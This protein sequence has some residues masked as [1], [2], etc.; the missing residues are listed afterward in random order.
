MVGSKWVGRRGQ[1][2]PNGARPEDTMVG[3]RWLCLWC[4]AVWHPLSTRG[5]EKSEN[6]R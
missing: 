5:A 6:Q 4:V 3:C 2:P 1:S